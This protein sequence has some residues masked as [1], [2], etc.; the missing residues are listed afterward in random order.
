MYTSL[1]ISRQSSGTEQTNL[2]PVPFLAHNFPKQFNCTKCPPSRGHKPT[3]QSN[4]AGRESHFQFHVGVLGRLK[5]WCQWWRTRGEVHEIQQH[6][7]ERES[8]ITK[9]E[10]QL[11]TSFNRDWY[12]VC[13]SLKVPVT[14][15]HRCPLLNDALCIFFMSEWQID[16]A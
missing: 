9:P 14:Y 3:G 12:R 16:S 5:P 6:E 8:S 4:R 15:R 7:R 10:A 11:G 13:T 1:V 2:Y